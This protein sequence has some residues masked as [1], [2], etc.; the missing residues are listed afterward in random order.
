MKYISSLG[1]AF[2][3]DASREALGAA[4]WDQYRWRTEHPKSPHREA[5]DIWL[6]YNAIENLGPHFNESHESV[7]YPVAEELPPLKHLAN[8]IASEVGAIELGG[9]LLTK[10]PAGKQVYR[11]VDHGWHAERYEKFAVLISGDERQSFCY[12]DGE[13]HSRAGEA[14]TFN[15]QACHWVK[16]PTN[17]DRVTLIVCARRH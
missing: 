11:H 15:N 13:F 6:R 2:N 12:E 9:V 14:F 5:S 1:F 8:V 16:N 4:P 7:W 17:I 3:V 10:V